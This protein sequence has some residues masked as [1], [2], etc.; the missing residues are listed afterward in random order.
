MTQRLARHAT[1]V[2]LICAFIA[3]MGLAGSIE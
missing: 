2:A 1:A 3:L